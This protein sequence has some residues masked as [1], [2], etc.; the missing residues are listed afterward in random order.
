VFLSDSRTS[1]IHGNFIGV[2]ATGNIALPNTGDGVHLA[3]GSDTNTIGTLDG[4]GR[5]VISGNGRNGIWIQ[6]GNSNTVFGNYIGTNAAGSG[7]VGNAQAGIVIST[8]PNTVGGSGAGGNLI[9]GNAA[10]ILL[11]PGS[12]GNQVQGN[13]IGTN[14]TGVGRVP[15]GEGIRLDGAASTAIGGLGSGQGNLI[16]GN[17]TGLA[18]VSG[19]NNTLAQNNLIGTNAAGTGPLSN[20]VGVSIDGNENAII[21]GTIAFNTG[22]GAVVVGGI[23]NNVAASIHSNGGLGIDLGGDGITPNDAGDTDT[24]PNSLQNFPVLTSAVAVGA[25]TNVSGTASGT[26]GDTL[27]LRFHATAS[28]D[29]TGNGEGARFLGEQ[30]ITLDVDGNGSFTIGVGTTAPGEVVTAT[31]RDGNGSVSEFSACVTVIGG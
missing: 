21:G 12:N 2:N 5:N 24:G 9:S 7:A 19:G 30:V 8:G 31:A 1:E 3:A 28:C 20:D 18:I 10:G 29:A 22:A 27:R 25:G 26:S 4:T 17:G 6:E 16:S 11:L 14:A 13:F 15:N 23:G